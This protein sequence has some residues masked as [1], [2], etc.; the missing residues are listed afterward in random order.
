MFGTV[1]NNRWFLAFIHR[2]QEG[3]PEVLNLLAYNPFPPDN[4]PQYVRAQL[5]D[6][7]FTTPEQKRETGDWWQREYLGEY[8]PA[9]RSP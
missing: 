5:Y 2:L 8:L 1:N 7:T 4:P 3:S 9:I 6:Y